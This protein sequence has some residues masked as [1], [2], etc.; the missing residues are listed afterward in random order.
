MLNKK[1]IKK[2]KEALTK[3]KLVVIPSKR[4]KK[5]SLSADFFYLGV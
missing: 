1:A 4:L 2:A 5:I 3:L